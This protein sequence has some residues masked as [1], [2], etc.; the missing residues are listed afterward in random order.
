[1]RPQVLPPALESFNGQFIYSLCLMRTHS[2]LRVV[3]LDDVVDDSLNQSSD[4]A[5]V[6]VF[7][8]VRLLCQPLAYFLPHLFPHR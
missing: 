4:T 5:Q 7:Y 8:A 6:G 1:M 2:D 3:D